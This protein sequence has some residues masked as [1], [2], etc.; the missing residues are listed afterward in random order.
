MV[1]SPGDENLEDV[2]EEDS[3]GEEEVVEKVDL[4]SEEFS[5]LKRDPEEEYFMLAVL[6]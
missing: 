1:D 5:Y 4:S 6:S 3:D 2:D